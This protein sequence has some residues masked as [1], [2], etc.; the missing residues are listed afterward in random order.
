MHLNF[1]PLKINIS[2]K[3]TFWSVLWTTGEMSA[4]AKIN[5]CLLLGAVHNHFLTVLMT[6]A[7]VSQ[8]LQVRSFAYT[9]LLCII[10]RLPWPDSWHAAERS[11]ASTETPTIPPVNPPWPVQPLPE[12]LQSPPEFVPQG[13]TCWVHSVVVLRWWHRYDLCP[14]GRDVVRPLEALPSRGINGV[15]GGTLFCFGKK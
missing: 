15:C 10:N 8:V 13:P 14:G 5:V 4:L 1:N 2:P 11:C 12:M 9:P 6:W 7:I 3:H